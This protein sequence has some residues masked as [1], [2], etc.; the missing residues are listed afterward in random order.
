[1]TSNALECCASPSLKPATPA[2]EGVAGMGRDH[3]DLGGVLLGLDGSIP[4]GVYLTEE[5][6]GLRGGGFV[7]A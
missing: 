1:M 4:S 7:L 6:D 5:A 2:A 3:G